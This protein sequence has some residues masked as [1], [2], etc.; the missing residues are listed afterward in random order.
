MEIR[1]S[2]TKEIEVSF[3][4]SDTSIVSCRAGGPICY[5]SKVTG[6]YVYVKFFTFQTCQFNVNSKKVRTKLTICDIRLPLGARCGS[7]LSRLN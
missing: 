2:K 3:G 4:H 6:A 7:P 1:S 5:R